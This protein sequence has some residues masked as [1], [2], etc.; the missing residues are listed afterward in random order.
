MVFWEIFFEM[1]PNGNFV[2]IAY[3][4]PYGNNFD[5]DQYKYH[6]ITVR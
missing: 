2:L 6:N 1:L 4:L 3:K 5:L